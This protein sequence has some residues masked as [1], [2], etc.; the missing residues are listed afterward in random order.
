VHKN[1][2]FRQE[3]TPNRKP[4]R[5]SK[6]MEA[7]KYRLL[8]AAS[9]HRHLFQLEALR[10]FGGVKA[11]EVGGFV[12][13]P[14]NLS[15]TG[16]CWVQSGAIVTGDA[17]VSED[18]QVGRFASVTGKVN[19]KGNTIVPEYASLKGPQRVDPDQEVSSI[20]LTFK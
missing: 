14:R 8:T 13:N 6:K 9:D 12:E 5:N 11:G 4:L 18:A 7:P 17:R 2:I 16:T 19:L 15:H 3:I 1:A 20:T 10:D